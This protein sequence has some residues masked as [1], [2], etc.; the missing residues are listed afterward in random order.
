MH[1]VI[2]F[3]K[4]LR[5]EE[6]LAFGM[7]IVG[8]AIL[9][10]TAPQEN[11]SALRILKMLVRYF[12]F[13][14]AFFTLFFVFIWI[15]VFVHIFLRISHLAIKLVVYKKHISRVDIVYALTTI[16]TPIR[17]LLP[18]AIVTIPTYGVLEVM[19]I[20]LRF[21]TFDIAF[22][23]AD[24]IIFGFSPFL[25]LPSVLS[26]PFFDTLIT[27]S[28][29]WLGYILSITGILLF[30]LGRMEALRRLLCAFLL[31]MLISYPLFFVLPCQD[32]N[33]F[34]IR[35]LR[36]HTLPADVLIERAA[37][38]PSVQITEIIRIIEKSE[39]DVENDN[40]VPISCFPSSHAMWALFVVYFLAT[41][42][43][44]SLIISIPWII[45]LLT[46]GIYFGQHYV[47]DY[48]VAL[49]IAFIC[50]WIAKTLIKEPPKQ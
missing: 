32:P 10:C 9:L 7:A 26:S 50:I 25:Y 15:A 45:L 23:T 34:F 42:S 33:N 35:N 48:V 14:D 21:T 43:S 38:T 49:P 13:G 20:H 27:Y 4:K 11:I 31:S 36:N 39:T 3:I 16:G 6:I 44:W 46:G 37:Y 2:G 5:P 1:R 19:S 28:Y 18:I 8:F 29:T 40:S 17:L 12:S 41:L 30:A 24:N 22:N 47:I